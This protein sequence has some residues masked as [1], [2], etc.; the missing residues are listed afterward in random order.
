[1]D[2]LSKAFVLF[3]VFL[4]CAIF[5]LGSIAVICAVMRFMAIP[6]LYAAHLLLLGICWCAGKKNLIDGAGVHNH[7][8]AIL[9][10]TKGGSYLTQKENIETFLYNNIFWFVM[11][12]L[13]LTSIVTMATIQDQVE[14]V[15]IFW[16]G[17]E[18]SRN[19]LVHNL[20]LLWA[21]YAVIML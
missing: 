16:Q 3:P 6:V 12:P 4:T 1:M 18:Y 13:I 19:I 11:Y 14:C 8:L 20:G 7:R 21:I 5:K 17:P 9:R 15:K 2:K 10:T